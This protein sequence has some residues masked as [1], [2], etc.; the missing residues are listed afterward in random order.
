[1]V[2]RITANIHQQAGRIDTMPDGSAQRPSLAWARDTDTGLFRPAP[3]NIGITTNGIER[4]R[5]NADAVIPMDGSMDLGTSSNRWKDLYLSGNT[6]H[7]GNATVSATGD[8]LVISNLISNSVTVSTID[9]TSN[10][11][12]TATVSI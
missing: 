2:L 9:V 5:I 10:I 8:A 11:T 3:N 6:I 4:V 7:V 1:M 12:T